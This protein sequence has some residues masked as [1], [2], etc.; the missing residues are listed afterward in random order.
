VHAQKDHA[1]DRSPPGQDVFAANE[2]SPRITIKQT[3]FNDLY[4]ILDML[5]PST[6]TARFLR[7]P[8][9]FGRNHDESLRVAWQLIRHSVAA[10]APEDPANTAADKSLN[11][12]GQPGNGDDE[13]KNARKR[14]HQARQGQKSSRNL[15]R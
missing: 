15:L 4:L 9:A 2:N 8:G 3:P 1:S 14:Q 5:L 11:D 6:Q 13:T 7:D 12:A 10:D